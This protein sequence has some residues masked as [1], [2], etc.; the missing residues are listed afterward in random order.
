MTGP[1]QE[2]ASRKLETIQLTRH[3]G[4]QEHLKVLDQWEQVS[5]TK[6]KSGSRLDRVRS[7]TKPQ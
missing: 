4:Y 3:V 6:P 5:A 1:R 2:G 7:G